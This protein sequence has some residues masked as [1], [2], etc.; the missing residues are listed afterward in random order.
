MRDIKFK[1][2]T[3]SQKGQIAI[4][5]DMRSRIGIRKGDELLLIQEGKKILIE[6]PEKISKKFMVSFK[7]LL[8]HSERVANKLWENKEDEVWDKI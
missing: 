7:Y 5:T 1:T 8:R 2:I 3:V 6:K 4:P